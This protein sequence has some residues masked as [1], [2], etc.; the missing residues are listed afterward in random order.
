VITTIQ[1]GEVIIRF[2]QP[3]IILH[4]GFQYQHLYI[5]V[6]TVITVY[7]QMTLISRLY[8]FEF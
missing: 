3:F 7:K 5:V 1:K 8:Y 4:S 6:I 2:L